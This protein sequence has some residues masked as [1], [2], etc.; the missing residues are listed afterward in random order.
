MYEPV[1]VLLRVL[2][3]DPYEK[4]S[5]TC[6]IICAFMIVSDMLWIILLLTKLIYTEQASEDA[7]KT[8]IK[9]FAIIHVSF[10]NEYNVLLSF[11]YV[12]LEKI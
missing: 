4:S 5:L 12:L 8:W 1:A 10:S 3:L 7:M 2:G 6:K 11:C 9:Y